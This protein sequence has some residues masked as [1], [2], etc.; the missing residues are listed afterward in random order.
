M[1]TSGKRVG[2]FTTILAGGLVGIAI[3]LGGGTT[4]QN[5]EIWRKDSNNIV[6]QF[7]TTL[8]T[9]VATFTDGGGVFATSS[10]G[11]AT[12]PST[13]YDVENVVEHNATAA[14]TATLTASTS[15]A[16]SFIPNAGDHRTLLWKNTGAGVLTLAGGTGSLLKV[17]SS[18]I[19]T[20]LKTIMPGGTATLD[21]FRTSNTD[22]EV[23]MSPAI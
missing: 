7:P 2:I 17:A 16:S 18:T 10:A 8:K 19:G 3:T 11:T 21:F 22:I 1:F 5:V 23:I 12:Y 13:A 20:G 15:V 4:A 14:L 6:R 9:V